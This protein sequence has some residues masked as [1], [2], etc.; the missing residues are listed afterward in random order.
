MMDKIRDIIFELKD[1]DIHLEVN[2]DK[3]SILTDNNL[4]PDDI[5]LIKSNK[6]EI[7]LFLKNQT[8]RQKLF[9]WIL[10]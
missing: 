3:L 2:G 6:D 4:N 10:Q 5:Y 8:F 7:I 1:N 9:I